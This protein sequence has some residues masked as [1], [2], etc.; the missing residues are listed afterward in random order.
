MDRFEAMRIF[1]RVAELK[2][3]TQAADSLYLPK[4]TVSTTIQR[5]E[6]RL[7]VRLLN[8]TTRRVQVTSEGQ[9]FY[10]RCHDLLLELEETESMFQTQPGQVRGKIRIDMTLA[11]AR[12]LVIPRL[13]E[14]LTQHPELEIELSSNDSF[15]DLIRQG[16]DCAIRVGQTTEPGLLSRKLGQMRL[17][18]CASPAYIARYGLPQELADLEKHYLVNY[19]QRL[20]DPAEGFEYFDGDSYRE[21]PM[22]SLISINTTDTYLA[23][24]L[25]GL[26]IIQCPISGLAPYLDSG[27]LI[28]ILAEY[29]AKAMPLRLIY[30]Y[31]RLQTRRLT[32]FIDWLEPII[33]D[34]L[35]I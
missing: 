34:Y 10:E 15:V 19:Q 18:N 35:E 22:K 20:G 28:P 17:I 26:G 13:P 11:L 8:R 5:L 32:V 7:Q 25:A 29:P 3:F 16:I 4:A 30:P 27:A 31:R 12:Q 23:S 33:Q 21:I 1:M 14:L 6:S 2:S 24:C 9:A